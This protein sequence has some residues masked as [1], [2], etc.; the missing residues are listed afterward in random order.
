MK[1][2]I[3]YVLS[4]IGEHFLYAVVS[5]VLMFILGAMFKKCLWVVSI[6]TSLLYLS[7][8]YSS[9]WAN[10]GRD[11]RAA[12]AQARETG[13]DKIE[14][15]ISRGFVYPLGMLAVSAVFL[16]LNVVFGS[17][18]TIMFRIY[19]FAFVFFLDTKLLPKLAVEII[20][21]VLPYILY[22]L[23][24]IAG[25]DKKIFVTK[26]LYKLIYKTKKDDKNIRR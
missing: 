10:A 23:G 4:A 9:G 18:F 21:T 17:Y 16:I 26:H 12:K 11:F 3:K 13:S 1:R 8:A 15:H 5:V 6:I 14:F 22:G 24:Y 20:I 2:E 25:K 19:N 7:T